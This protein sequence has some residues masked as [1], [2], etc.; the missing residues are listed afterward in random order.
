MSGVLAFLF[1][2]LVLV[3]GGAMEALLP[4]PLGV[5]VPILLGWTLCASVRRAAPVVV[6]LALAAGAFEDA[7]ASLPA[8]TSAPF[9]VVVALVANRLHWAPLVLLVAYP[10]Y[11]VWLWAVA[12][13]PASALGLACALA[14][15]M[16]L[17]AVVFVAFFAWCERK[18]AIA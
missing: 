9:F 1:Q 14:V 13:V 11:E 12:R 10:L 6:V 7:L 3:L 2:V 4:K 16:A 15:P 8:L 5:G 17:A 18:A